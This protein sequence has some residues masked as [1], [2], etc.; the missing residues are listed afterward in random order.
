MKNKLALT[1]CL[2][3]GMMS[4]ANAQ[5]DKT[6]Y[7]SVFDMK[8]AFCSIKT[9]GVIGQDNRDD[10]GSGRGFATGSTSSILLMENGENDIAVEMASVNW[11]NPEINGDDK[12]SF[13]K[14]AYCNLD[15]VKYNKEGS[16]VLSNIKITI[17]D[18]G[19][20]TVKN[21]MAY[22]SHQSTNLPINEQHLTGFEVTPGF[23]QRNTYASLW[24]PKGM[25]IY[26]FSKKVIVN[27]LPEWP[28]V[29]A[30]PYTDTP[31]QRQLL[32][33]AYGELWQAFNNK[34]INKIKKLMTLSFKAFGYV[35][36]STEEEILKDRT[37]YKDIT[38]STF[39]MVPIDW[40][41]YE[42]KIMNN[43][44]MI[45]LVN[46]TDPDF[47]PISYIYGKDDYSSV[48]PIFSLINDRFVVVL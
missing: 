33:Q 9:N 42:V 1:L 4:I 5:V 46:K 23:T 22:P 45:R 10:A 48:A 21:S 19:Q 28:W 31:E 29:K 38:D 20:P 40:N 12:N 14:D 26:E 37:F 41:A 2:L 11:F 13:R 34:D 16:Q 43:G 15:L 39:K 17:D 44:R 35:S 24:Y 36:N 27:G 18:D 8:Y 32:Q 3:G 6:I 7:R 47:S 25:K 30:T